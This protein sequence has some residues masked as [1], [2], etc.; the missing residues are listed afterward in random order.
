[1]RFTL[2]VPTLNELNGLK[3]IMPRVKREWVDQILVV[4][5]GSTDGTVGYV[6]EQGWDLH[7]QKEKGLHRAYAEA[8]PLIEGDGVITFSPDGNCI[9]EA[10]PELTAKMEEGYDMVVASRYLGSAKS[11]DDGLVTAFGNWL[12]TRVLINGL[13]GGSYTD[14]FNIYRAYRTKLYYELKLDRRASYSVE[15]I[16][17]TVIGVE[18]LLSTRAVK[19]GCRLGEIASDEPA[20]IGGEAKLQVVRWGGAYLFQIL[21]ELW[22]DG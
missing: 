21:R 18:P 1:M 17:S 8:W 10:I 15:K 12:F 2:F 3:A 7:V 5:G 9:P 4:D 6:K 22:Y 11:E 16:W 14:A 19:A 20:R 13:H